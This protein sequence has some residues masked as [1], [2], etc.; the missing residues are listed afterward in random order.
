MIF[1]LA[2]AVPIESELARRGHRLKPAGH[3][4]VGPCPVCGGRDRFAV[5]TK[6]R[7]WNC[8]GCG[9]GGDVIDLV[10]HLDGGTTTEAVR[11][12]TGMSARPTSPTRPTPPAPKSDDDHKRR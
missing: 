3:E 1:T 11:T 6:K 7:V 5:H 4:L 10:K 2:K 8:R 12:L 9:R